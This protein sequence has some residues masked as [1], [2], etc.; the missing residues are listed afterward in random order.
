MIEII[1]SFQPILNYF[2]CRKLKNIL[3]ANI[4]IMTVASAPIGINQFI[5]F[6][7]LKNFRWLIN[8]TRNL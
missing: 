3:G 1:L 5:V 2:I 6:F 8:S 7:Y 4:R